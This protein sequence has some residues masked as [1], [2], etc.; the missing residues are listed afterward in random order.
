MG[1]IVCRKV[2]R[3]LRTKRFK[4]VQY[5]NVKTF[6]PRLQLVP[7]QP[8]ITLTIEESALPQATVDPKPTGTKR[9]KRR[10]RRFSK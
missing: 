3:G 8:D 1:M 2:L 4:V 7:R 10:A 6:I 5:G 9:T